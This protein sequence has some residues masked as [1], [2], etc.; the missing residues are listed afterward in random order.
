[1]KS[2]SSHFGEHLTI[3]GYEGEFEKLNSQKL[4]STCLNELPGL[5]G[6]EKLAS[7]EVYSAPEI[8]SKDPGG[9]SGYVVITESHISIHTFPKR[10][11][12]SADVYSC[13]CGMD[14]DFIIKYFKDKFSLKEVETNFIKRGIRYPNKN[15]C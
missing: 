9:W 10:G 5:L 1:M 11:F 6:M 15:I 13:K 14:R 12:I 3:D 7:P 8:N 4:V 2:A